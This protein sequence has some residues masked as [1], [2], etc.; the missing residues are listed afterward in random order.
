MKSR[1]R[2]KLKLLQKLKK[3]QKFAKF[4]ESGKSTKCISIEGGEGPN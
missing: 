2:G 1:G 4:V 3:M